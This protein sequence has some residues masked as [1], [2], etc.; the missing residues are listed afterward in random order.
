VDSQATA[1]ALRENP[2]HFEILAFWD[3]PEETAANV[4]W[5]VDYF[6]ETSRFSSGEVYVNS[7]DEDEG[8]RIREA[9]GLNYERLR[10][11]KRKYDPGNFFRSNQNIPSA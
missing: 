10:E 5:M 3:R 9:Y 6:A 4:K 7:L 11:L 8:G 2:Y 1:F